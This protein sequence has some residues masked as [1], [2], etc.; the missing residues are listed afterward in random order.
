MKRRLSSTTVLIVGSFVM[1]TTLL[2]LGSLYYVV[3]GNLEFLTL[4]TSLY[5]EKFSLTDDTTTLII[6]WFGSII[7]V[8][9]VLLYLSVF[10]GKK[11]TTVIVREMQLARW[12]LEN[13]VYEDEEPSYST[14]QGITRSTLIEK[15]NIKEIAEFYSLVVNIKDRIKDIKK[16]EKKA[17]ESYEQVQHLKTK[18]LAIM[19][20]DLRSPLNSI[21]GFSEL[22]LSGS[23]G[24]LTQEQKNDIKIIYE[25][26]REL[27]FLINTVLQWARIEIDIRSLEREWYPSV[28]LLTSVIEEAQLLFGSRKINITVELQP[29][30]PPF[31]IDKDRMVQALL[32]IINT[33]LRFEPKD[34]ILVKMFMDDKEKAIVNEVKIHRKLTDEEKD[35]LFEA[36]YGMDR[37][38]NVV[39]YSDLGLGMALA[40]AIIE[41]HKGS[42]GVNIN[43]KEGL[44]SFVVKI[45]IKPT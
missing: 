19:S 9:G 43:E 21:L 13:L 38:D 27:L 31:Y 34:Y 23:E 2:I 17:I 4:S 24:E 14:P 22:L 7:I 16:K 15:I 44:S 42:I 35:S 5:H 30:L 33:A 45:P 1:P 41:A 26:G 25:A 6:L 12:R 29:G 36:F 20:H 28:E 10:I 39:A 3:K 8:G 18:F 11:F 32:C 40:K 37:I